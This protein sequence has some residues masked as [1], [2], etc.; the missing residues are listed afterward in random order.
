MLKQIILHLHSELVE[1]LKNM[2]IRCVVPDA[3]A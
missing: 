3:K 1:S 2:P